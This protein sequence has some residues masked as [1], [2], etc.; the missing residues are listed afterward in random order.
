MGEVAIAT[1]MVCQTWI[2]AGELAPVQ[3]VQARQT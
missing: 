2:M 1:L 3:I